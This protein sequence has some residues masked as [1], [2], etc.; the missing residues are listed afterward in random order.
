MRARDGA[1]FSCVRSDRVGGVN[2]SEPQP[3]RAAAVRPAAF[4]RGETRTVGT[5]ANRPSTA[6]ERPPRLYRGGTP[7]GS[8]NNSGFLTQA[9]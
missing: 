3:W 8:A 1:A 9:R 2:G 7:K 6:E 5:E 4:L